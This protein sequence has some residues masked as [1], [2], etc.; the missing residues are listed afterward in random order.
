MASF[1]IIALVVAFLTGSQ[2][3]V[4]SRP[5]LLVPCTVCRC[6]SPVVARL[7]DGEAYVDFSE[8][9]ECVISESG[10]TCMSADVA[11]P[12]RIDDLD[13]DLRQ[14]PT[15]GGQRKPPAGMVPFSFQSPTAADVE[16]P[17]EPSASE[18]PVEKVAFKK[19]KLPDKKKKQFKKRRSDDDE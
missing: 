15:E 7:G 17:S 16:V 11:G 12:I 6:S 8:D 2:A 13:T 1:P 4:A 19:R 10:S 14:R 5:A 3:L 18:E 9:D